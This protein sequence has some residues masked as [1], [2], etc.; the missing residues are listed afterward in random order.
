MPIMSPGTAKLFSPSATN[1]SY[2]GQ[3]FY[4]AY[5]QQLTIETNTCFRAIDSV[6][7]ITLGRA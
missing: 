1:C 4:D 5:D 6:N 7:G 3:Q 2:E